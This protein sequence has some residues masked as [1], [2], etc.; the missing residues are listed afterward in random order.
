M[1]VPMQLRRLLGALLVLP[2][3]AVSSAV[4][5][6][7]LPPGAP[8]ISPGQQLRLQALA[9]N[10]H[11]WANATLMLADW[12]NP[13]G[14][15][16]QWDTLA[17]VMT[18]NPDYAR[19]AIDALLAG[20]SEVPGNANETRENFIHFALHYAW[21]KDQMTL[22]QRFEY[23]RRLRK[24]SAIVL[25]LDAT[26]SFGTR[27]DDSDVV[28]GHHFGLALTR[29]VT[30]DEP[31]IDD[32][33]A[34]TPGPKGSSFQQQRDQI[35]EFCR[36]ADGGEW[37][38][39]SSYN[40]GTLSLLFLGA[41]AVGID[42]YPEVAELGRQVAEWQPWIFTPD[43]KDSAE[44]GDDS[45]PRDPELWSRVGLLAL[46]C[47]QNLDATAAARGLLERLTQGVKPYPNYWHDLYRAL[48]TF[49]PTSPMPAL[50][51]PQPQGARISPGVGLVL[52]RGPEHLFQ[53]NAPNP[54]GVDH[55]LR[56]NADVRLWFRGEWVIDC[57]RGYDPRANSVNDVQL[58]GLGSMFDHRLV[59]TT[60]SETGLQAVWQTR[61][62]SYWPT[63]Y[64]PP[65][66][67][68]SD[69][70]RTVNFTAPNRVVVTDAFDGTDPRQLPLL[71]RYYPN[72]R[73][74]I[75]AR[76]ALWTVLWHCPTEPI[77]LPN[78]YRWQTASGRNVTLSFKVSR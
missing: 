5:A 11:P 25:D 32:L 22:D 38:E 58:S 2:L 40:P 57:P 62:S 30:A 42:Q 33:I 31:L 1:P 74:A 73:Q 21:L 56:H 9:A 18:K 43:L 34:A 47:G 71:D 49:D 14:D 65:P 50:V 29:L 76:P 44:W 23:R 72:D 69:Y 3:T 60:P 35:A 24:W 8:L 61:G 26:P 70:T 52:H 45:W 55:Q 66:D 20:F 6:D 7:V 13:Y 53:F 46:L 17:W 16:G 10:Q 67:F 36:R 51:P 28:V 41:S 68:V 19:S 64:N 77:A 48:Y 59:S 37:I 75:D 63:F 78:G 27:L 4:Q 15:L 39:S 54:V 12:P